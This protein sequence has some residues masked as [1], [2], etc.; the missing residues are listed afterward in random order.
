MPAVGDR[1]PLAR[2]PLRLPGPLREYLREEAAGGVVLMPYPGEGHR[3]LAYFKNGTYVQGD[4]H[5]KVVRK[6]S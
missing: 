2:P 5:G 6:I 4:R 1:G 3:W